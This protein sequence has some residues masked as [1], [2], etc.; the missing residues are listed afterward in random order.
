MFS[1]LFEVNP[2]ADQWDTYL[3]IAKMLRPELEQIDGFIDNIRYASLT[4]PG[5]L[6][7]LSGWRDEKSLVRWRVKTNHH[8]AQQRG[9]D[10]VFVDY[11]L[12]IGQI[13]ADTQLPVGHLLREQRLDETEAGAGTTVTLLDAKRTPEWVKQAGADAIAKSLGLD[14]QAADLVA[15]DVFDAVLTPGDVIA[16]IT[17]RDQSAAEAFERHAAL[18]GDTRVRRIRIIR[19]YGMFD[20]REAPQYYPE[21]QRST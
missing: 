13:T 10:R 9:R 12:R 4:R 2:K 7:S 18:T 3:G 16:M 14:L 17:W 5:W 15:W 1:V 20:R 6:L 11:H 21:A 8:N 19:D